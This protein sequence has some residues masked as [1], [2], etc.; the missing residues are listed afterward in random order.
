MQWVTPVPPRLVEFALDSQKNRKQPNPCPLEQPSAYNYG[1]LPRQ[2]CHV[3]SVLANQEAG[4]RFSRRLFEPSI[5][6]AAR[7]ISQ[8]VANGPKWA[9]R[10][11]VR[12]ASV[13]WTGCLPTLPARQGRRPEC[14]LG[15]RENAAT[16]GA[17][18]LR[19]STF[20]GGFEASPTIAFEL[21][22]HTLPWH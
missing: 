5:S 13:I 16:R 6:C 3:R 7:W 21:D 2:A 12:G 20:D 19:A 10:S 1:S 18:S 15:D 9:G 8:K 11:A 4:G 14:G 17:L 22:S